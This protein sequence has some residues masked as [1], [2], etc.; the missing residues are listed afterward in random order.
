MFATRNGNMALK[1]LKLHLEAKIE[2]QFF[3]AEKYCIAL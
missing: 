2:L 1:L 3:S